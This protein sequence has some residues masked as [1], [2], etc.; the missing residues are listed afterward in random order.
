MQMHFEV[1][2]SVTLL[3]NFWNVHGPGGMFL[4]VLVVLL[5]TVMYELL[6]VWK[7]TLAKRS[8]HL[9]SSF[10]AKLNPGMEHADSS[11]VATAPSETS[12]ISSLSSSENAAGSG[13]STLTENRWFLRSVQTGLHVIQVVLGYMLMLCVMSYNV[14]I[15]LGV[16]I[17]SM[18]GYFVAFPFLEYVK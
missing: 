6:K 9:A 17:G 7:I 10:P 3:F 11:S 4:S 2:D 18:L 5:L 8:E 1:S 13:F 15:F 12:I 14:W 16:I